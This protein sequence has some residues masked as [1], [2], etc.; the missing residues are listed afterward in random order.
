MLFIVF[1]I[2]IW[3][4]V[5]LIYVFIFKIVSSEFNNGIIGFGDGVGDGF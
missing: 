2:K 4:F 5:K 3:C 1:N